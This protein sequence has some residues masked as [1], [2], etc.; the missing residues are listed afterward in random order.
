MI[1]ANRPRCAY[2]DKPYGR[3]ATHM[4]S[5]SWPIDGK[6]PRYE[7]NGVIVKEYA[8]YKTAS[9]GTMRAL[10][11]RTANPAL[12]AQQEAELAKTPE[13]SRWVAQYEVWDGEKIDGTPYEP[14][15]TLR[16]ALAY[17]RK[18]YQDKKRSR[19]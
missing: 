18:A 3:R 4:E 19:A 8:P 6:R 5:C 9:R 10:Q 17:A 11:A 14:F 2:C 1:K 7:G 16:C 12:R 15:C 13:E